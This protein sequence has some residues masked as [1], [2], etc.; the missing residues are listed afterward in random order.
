MANEERMQS[1]AGGIK[2]MA[3]R[4]FTQELKVK[5]ARLEAVG[6]GKSFRPD[7]V[8]VREHRRFE[9]VSDPDDTS[10]LYA[11]ETDDGTKGVLVDGYGAYAD[12]AVAAF[13]ESVRVEQPSV[14][15]PQVTPPSYEKRAQA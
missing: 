6:S 1:L 8:V 5:G 2:E 13:L 12:A 3:G 15:N 11:I 7:Q 10:V 4:G 14:K 9:G